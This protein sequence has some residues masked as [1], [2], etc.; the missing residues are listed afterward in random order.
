LT[1]RIP[2]S[3]LPKSGGIISSALAHSS[4]CFNIEP[5][6]KMKKTFS[7]TID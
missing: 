5:Y 2:T 3:C 1:R 7:E 4:S 6:G